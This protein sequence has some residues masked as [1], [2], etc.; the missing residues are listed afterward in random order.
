MP[1]VQQQRIDLWKAAA[2]AVTQALSIVRR[3]SILN[4][5]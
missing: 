2:N 5:R 4:E 1:L 3:G